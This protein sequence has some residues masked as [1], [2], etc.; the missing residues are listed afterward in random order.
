MAF[1]VPQFPIS[2]NIWHYAT[3]FGN[4]PTTIPAPDVVS[5]CNLALGKRISP[6]SAFSMWLLLPAL[7]DIRDGHKAPTSGNGDCVEVP[8]GSGRYYFVEDVDDAGKGFSNEH[9][10]AAITHDAVSLPF[11]PEW[12]VPYP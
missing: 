11:L 4:F 1:V 8:A 7:T 3:W 6:S 2:C 9:R 5:L 12:P 10:V